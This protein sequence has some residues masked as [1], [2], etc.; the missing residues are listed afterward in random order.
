MMENFNKSNLKII[1]RVFSKEG[2]IKKT[3]CKIFFLSNLRFRHEKWFG[4]AWAS[5]SSII[6]II[7]TSASPNKPNFHI[8]F[9]HQTVWPRVGVV[10]GRRGWRRGVAIGSEGGGR[11]RHAIHTPIGGWYSERFC[12]NCWLI[13]PR[14]VC[15]V[16]VWGYVIQNRL[17]NSNNMRLDAQQHM[18]GMGWD[19]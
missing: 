13:V 9:S 18:N 11:A 19:E 1:Y 14:S 12:G 8:H 4:T 7:A 15:E 10:W 2:I 17:T 5:Y 16:K 6:G 3:Y